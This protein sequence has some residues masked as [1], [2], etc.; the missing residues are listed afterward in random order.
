[1]TLNDFRLEMASHLRSAHDEAESLKDQYVVLERLRALYGKFDS[2]ER[3]MADQVLS[4][5][6][7][8]EDELFRFDALALIYDLKIEAAVPALHMLAT[9]LASSTVP[10]A[11]YELKKVHGILAALVASKTAR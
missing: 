1:M 3:Q 9:R 6:A 10:S 2:A 5:W 8:S 11:P 7:L 4:E